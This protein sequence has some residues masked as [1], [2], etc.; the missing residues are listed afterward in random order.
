MQLIGRESSFASLTVRDA[1]E[2]PGRRNGILPTYQLGARLLGRFRRV[3][4]MMVVSMAMSGHR[5]GT[6]GL[7][8][9]IRR[10]CSC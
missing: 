10:W 2:L 7:S 5:G 3:I 1:M 9:P 4:P 6:Y 8:T